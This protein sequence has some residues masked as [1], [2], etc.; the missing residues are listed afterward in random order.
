MCSPRIRISLEVVERVRRFFVVVAEL[1]LA[2]LLAA[3]VS[4]AQISDGAVAGNVA[5][6]KGGRIVGAAVSI[7]DPA[8]G[9]QRST[10]TN[11]AGEFRFEALRPGNYRLS[12]SAKGFKQATVQVS[13]TVS[14]V[15]TVSIVMHPEELRQTVKVTGE[16][17][18]LSAQPIETT[19]SIEKTTI[20]SEDLATFPL[21]HR[22]FANIAY[23]APMTEPVEP[24]DPTKARITAVSFAGSSGL[25][26]D[27]SVDGGDNNDDYIGGFLQNYSPDAIQEFTVRTAQFD[28]DTSRTNGGSVIISTRRGTDGWHGSGA[29][30]YRGRSLN[31]RNTLDNPEADP[32][33]PF[34]RHNEVATLGGPL[35]K[36]KLWFF[37]SFEYVDEDA[38]VAYSSNSQTQFSALAQL[39]S[40][41]L[42]PGVSSIPVPTAVPVPFRDAQFTTRLDWAQSQ[43]SLWFFRGALDHNHTTNDLVQQAALPSTGATTHSNYGNFLLSQQYQFNESWLGVFTAEASIFHHTKD[44]NSR[45]GLALAFPFSANFH[46]TSG[47]ETFG[48][49]QFA[50]AIT[51]F[52]VLRDQ[53]KY[54]LRYDVSRTAG[55]HAAKF[56][57]N[58]IHEP[59]LSGRL[60]NDLETLAQFPE[61]PSF[62][63]GD[64]AQFTADFN[65]LQATVG[66]PSPPTSQFCLGGNGKFSQSLRRLGLYAQDS[67]RARPRLTINFGLRYDTTFG[68][69]RASGRDQDQNPAILTLAVLGIPLV[70]GIPHDYRGAVAPRLGIAY[71][72]GGS[73]NTVLRAGVGLFYNDLTQNGWADAFVDVNQ[74]LP[75]GFLLAPGE[76]GALIDPHYKTPY[77]LQASAGVEHAFASGWRLNVHYEHQQGVHQFRRYE[78]VSGATL[79]ASAPNISLFRTDNRSRYDGVAFLVQRRFSKRYELTA[80]YTLASASTWGATVGELFDYVN[81]VS[82]VRNP[83]GAGDYGP[84]GEDVRHRLVIAGT[85]RLPGNLEIAT[86]AQ[87]ESARPFTL[88]T[89]VDLNGDGLDSNDRAV[90]NGVPTRLDQ[91]RG[92]PF[93][94]TDLR[95]GREFRLGERVALLPFVEFFNL[96][97]R[98]N[99]GNNFV[100]DLAALPTP[101]NDLSNATAFCLNPICTQTRPIRSPNDLRVPAG[102]LGDFFGPGTTIGIPFAAQ[103]GIRL[104]F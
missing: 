50:T 35:R 67:W 20:S 82:D 99:P 69:F 56:G 74:P 16:T 49:N 19:S 4:S 2:A 70:S 22:S 78:Y 24:S 68:L 85:M 39:A 64:T 73:G 101:V 96:F 37:S 33:Q 98:T 44:R 93:Y 23:L 29:F 5:D 66:C 80:H 102:A 31:A 97:N 92:T 83:F 81:G 75:A 1:I 14:S 10:K 100:G 95:V 61:D 41:G 25:N 103:V 3:G 32:K 79:P 53:Q 45:L 90:V 15:P 94:Q 48:D 9:F 71:S 21:A 65:A 51:A 38:S 63:L 55:T 86:L 7:E 13:V 54:Q 77:A 6:A 30:Y 59:V 87:F 17:P 8:S 91:F 12:V 58:F 104:T 34:S 18:T 43:H 42:I 88:A 26:V 52:P 40:L 36:D 84:S 89:P 62:Y 47:F 46:T 11:G 76:Q 27:L 28:A 57:V 60:A 72:P